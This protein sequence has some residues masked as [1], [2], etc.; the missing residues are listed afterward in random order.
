MTV[1]SFYLFVEDENH[2]EPVPWFLN[3]NFKNLLS[4]NLECFKNITFEKNLT[5]KLYFNKSISND[6][7]KFFLEDFKFQI[8]IY[9][10]NLK[11]LYSKKF[12]GEFYDL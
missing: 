12:D 10:N 8:S 5:G 3:D 6:E 2:H 4:E 1:K 7:F 11:F 9:N